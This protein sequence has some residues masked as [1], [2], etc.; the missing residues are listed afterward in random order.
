MLE[1]RITNFTLNDVFDI[2][3][4][5][6]YPL[7]LCSLKYVPL[8][9]VSSRTKEVLVGQLFND[10][11]RTAKLI[12]NKVLNIVNLIPLY[13]L[14]KS[15]PLCLI[16][17]R[18]NGHVN[19]H[20]ISWPS[21]SETYKTWQIYDKEMTL[22]FNTHIPSESQLVVYIYQLS[23]HRLQYFLKNSLFSLFPVEKPT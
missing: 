19:A 15:F 3:N 21:K 10:A 17:H 16:N 11:Q 13:A 18:T 8:S 14:V 12:Q 9:T 23:G 2:L 1:E 7:S 22:T 5:I 20:L 4:F 6:V